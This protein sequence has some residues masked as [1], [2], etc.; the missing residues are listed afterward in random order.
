MTT[1]PYHTQVCHS[2]VRPT[3]SYHRHPQ[4]TRLQQGTQGTRRQI[5]PPTTVKRRSD[6]SKRVKEESKWS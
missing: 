5:R 6:R 3:R 4:Q 2:Q 1:I